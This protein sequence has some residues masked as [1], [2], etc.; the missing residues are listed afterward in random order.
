MNH[1]EGRRL[2]RPSVPNVVMDLAAK[3]VSPSPKA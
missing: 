3:T 1:P 2:I